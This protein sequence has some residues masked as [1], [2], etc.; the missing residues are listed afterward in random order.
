[1]DANRALLCILVSTDS[2]RRLETAST[3]ELLIDINMDQYVRAL[4]F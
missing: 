1:M 3:L 2:V 4:Q